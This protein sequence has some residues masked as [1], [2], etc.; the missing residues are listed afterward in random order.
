M[1]KWIKLSAFND[2]LANVQNK[3]K[4]FGAEIDRIVSWEEW[5]ALIQPYYY[6]RARGNKPY[7]LELMLKIYLLQNLYNL[8]DMRTVAEVIVS[9]AFSDFCGV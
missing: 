5:I 2:A 4:E 6:K 3:E 1:D 8:S 9:R 7:G